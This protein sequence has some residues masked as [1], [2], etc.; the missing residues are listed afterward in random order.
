M[1]WND[2][3]AVHSECGKSRKGENVTGSGGASETATSV[4]ASWLNA[5]DPA[6]SITHA[7]HRPSQP[8]AIRAPEAAVDL[9]F[10][11]C[12]AANRTGTYRILTSGVSVSGS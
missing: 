7:I 12:H 2:T 10:A 4:T 6:A 11:L 3:P 1:G 8:K 5:G 9:S